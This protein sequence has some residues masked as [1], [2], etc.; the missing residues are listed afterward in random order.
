[1]IYELEPEEFDQEIKLQHKWS[2]KKNFGDTLRNTEE[3]EN[4]F[5]N[6]ENEIFSKN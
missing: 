6:N 2:D 4:N 1:M 5:Q 3:I